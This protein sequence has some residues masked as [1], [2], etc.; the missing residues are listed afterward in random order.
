MPRVE[1]IK[2][3]SNQPNNFI[4]P[5]CDDVV[6]TETDARSSASAAQHEEEQAYHKAWQQIIDQLIQWGQHPSNVDEDDWESPA[7]DAI[8]AAFRLVR[9]L[10]KERRPPPDRVVPNGEGGIVFELKSGSKTETFEIDD[11]GSVEYMYFQNSRLVKRE[12]F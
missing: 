6:P 7:N 8:G 5:M 11:D 1:A 9:A 10:R 4:T 3:V 2:H 12:S